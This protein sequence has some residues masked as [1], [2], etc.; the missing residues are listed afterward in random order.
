MSWRCIS[1][2]GAV[3]LG[4]GGGG[5]DS[6][7]LDDLSGELAAASCERTFACCDAAEIE[8]ELGFFDVE[9]EGECSTVIGAFIEQFLVPGLRS[10]VASGRLVYHGDRMG[11]CLSLLRSVGC[12]ELVEGDALSLFGLGCEDPFEGQVA[13][14]DAC[15]IDEECAT[16]FCIG[17]SQ[18]FEG[19]VT[20]GVCGDAPGAGEPCAD[21]DCA[22]G[23]WCDS[24]DPEG[25]TCAEPQDDGA[26][27]FSDEE[28]ASDNCFDD[29]DF[30]G[31]PGMCS[32]E[33]YCDGV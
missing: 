3:L 23:A 17:E 16:D 13:N 28:C 24:S 14:G 19:N 33:P 7:S 32:G 21:F 29:D 15:A 6:V 22:E 20:E 1:I 25:P 18:D 12:D 8:S 31:E 10:G 4:C 9:T 30:D 5:G 2:L 26:S 11:A 27:C